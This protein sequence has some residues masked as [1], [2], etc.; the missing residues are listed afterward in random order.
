[1][2]VYLMQLGNSAQTRGYRLV[3]SF[4]KDGGSVSDTF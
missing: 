2:I 1:M 3:F 4:A